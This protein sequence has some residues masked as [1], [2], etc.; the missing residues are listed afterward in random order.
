MNA[1]SYMKAILYTVF[2]ISLVT[3]LV[4]AQ[5]NVISSA[6]C[7]VVDNVR[8]F[9]GILALVLF[10][11]G[12]I[13]YATAHFLPTAGQLKG[14]MQGWAMGML[15]G[16]VLGIILVILAQPIVTLITGFSNTVSAP[17]C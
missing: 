14:S 5:A 13:L 7:G 16:G 1:I 3:P 2:A 17:S 10:I 8:L 6:L 15:M 4:S 9:V 12:G 11:L